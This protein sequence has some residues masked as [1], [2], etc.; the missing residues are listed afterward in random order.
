MANKE[1]HISCGLVAIYA[2]VVNAKGNAFLSKSDCTDE[3]FVAVVD[4]LL[5]YG[6]SGIEVESSGGQKVLLS[7]E[8]CEDYE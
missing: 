2:G 6:Y 4:Y 3:A 8:E 5:M 7:I 1:Y